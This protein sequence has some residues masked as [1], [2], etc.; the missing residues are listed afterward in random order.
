MLTFYEWRELGGT[1]SISRKEE[2]QNSGEAAIIGLLKSK[3][4]QAEMSMRE[5]INR[6]LVAGTVDTATFV[7][8]NSA[9]DMNPL[10]WFFRQDNQ[11]DPT[12]GG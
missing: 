1:I 6:Q 10:G 2:R 8:G 11:V 12:T 4:M 5:E 7:P 9:K 3:I